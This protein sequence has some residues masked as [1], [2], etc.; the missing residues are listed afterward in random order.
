MPL[1]GSVSCPDVINLFVPSAV[2]PLMR[3]SPYH[4]DSL[5]NAISS[6]I[7]RHSP[8]LTPKVLAS[9]LGLNGT[10]QIIRTPLHSSSPYLYLWGTAR[11]LLT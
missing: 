4:R 3:P 7:K 9:M 1:F 11:T 5:Y 6:I 8:R 2:S 10:T